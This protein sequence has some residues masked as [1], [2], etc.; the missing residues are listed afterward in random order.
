MS[1]AEAVATAGGGGGGG[2]AMTDAGDTPSWHWK[3][4]EIAG[5]TG[6]WVGAVSAGG[7]QSFAIVVRSTP[8]LPAPAPAPAATHTPSPTPMPTSPTPSHC[9]AGRNPAGLSTQREEEVSSRVTAAEVEVEA[10]RGPGGGEEEVTMDYFVSLGRKG[11]FTDTRFRLPPRLSFATSESLLSQ[12][13]Y[14]MARAMF[15]KPEPWAKPGELAGQGAGMSS[16]DRLERT[17]IE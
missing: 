15:E 16:W 17:L 13:G 3:P 10:G 12:T 7:E 4:R 9:P 6:K 5:L 14:V 8:S 1:G 11:W 2:E